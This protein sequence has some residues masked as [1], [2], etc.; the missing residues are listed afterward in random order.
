MGAS[1][2]SSEMIS[3]PLQSQSQ[4]RAAA[5]VPRRRNGRQQACEPCRRRKVGC[6]HQLPVCSRCRRGRIASKCI[7]LLPGESPPLSRAQRVSE[8]VKSPD[9]VRRDYNT[10]VV[11]PTSTNSA[12]EDK[13]R[14]G[15]G[16]GYMG[17]TS[18]TAV[19]QEAERRLSS[20][21]PANTFPASSAEQST[22]RCPAM[23]KFNATEQGIAVI[24]SIP[25]RATAYYLFDLYQNVT[26]PWCRLATER[27]HDSMWDAFGHILDGERDSK[28]LGD[29]AAKLCFNT[30]S[31]LREDHTD[32][33]IWF[34]EFSGPNLRWEALGILFTCWT[35]SLL[36]LQCDTVPEACPSIR[37]MNLMSAIRL[38][39]D[40]AWH[41]SQFCWN[42]CE[43]TTL[44]CLLLFKHSILESITSGDAG[45]DG[46]TF[47]FCFQ[48]ILIFDNVDIKHWRLHGDLV[49]LTTYLGLH[50]TTSSPNDRSIC[51]QLQRR[52]FASIFNMDKVIAIFTGRPP[53]LSRRFISTYLPLDITD[54]ELL[55]D[56]TS[57]NAVYKE[58]DEDGWN[59]EG[60][61]YN[62][63]HL[64]ARALMS[65]I[66]DAILEIALRT[67]L[68]DSEE[69][70]L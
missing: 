9:T 16:L 55:Q 4:S 22:E 58:L 25:D 15:D 54:E 27:I 48:C 42:A 45:K 24:R 2:E 11:T 8:I 46:V 64:R 36:T 1:F 6:D 65:F 23:M 14:T 21:R 26:E 59:K 12:A 39:K 3:P 10:P 56:S 5:S 28:S 51:V 63:T 69:T 38:Y 33:R 62:T 29:M 19:L 47:F 20:M 66:R 70:I 34:A 44:L 52:L 68:Y 7:Y 49:A 30:A 35:G 53:M 61:I 31:K 43:G 50:T 13:P 41:C 67:T 40:D 57:T 32:P 60:V 17:A 18:F 37:N